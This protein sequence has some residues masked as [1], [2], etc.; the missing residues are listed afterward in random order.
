MKICSCLAIESK[1]D[2]DSQRWICDKLK[3]TFLHSKQSNWEP[4]SSQTNKFFRSWWL[5]PMGKPDPL[6]TL[7]DSEVIITGNNPAHLPTWRHTCPKNSHLLHLPHNRK[8]LYSTSHLSYCSENLP[9][10]F[11]SGFLKDKG[12]KIWFFTNAEHLK[13]CES[14]QGLTR[15]STSANQ[16]W[17]RKNILITS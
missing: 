8:K 1:H 6:G 9:L 10:V 4:Q 15:F 13:S 12:L 17:S 2:A 11:G 7:H 14:R 3:H 5:N 16:S